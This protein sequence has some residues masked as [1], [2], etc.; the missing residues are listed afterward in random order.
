M[1]CWDGSFQFPNR[2]VPFRTLAARQS[3]VRRAYRG[4]LRKHPWG[5][6]GLRRTF[7][8]WS[9]L[10]S[11]RGSNR[12]GP[13]S[14]SG[15]GSPSLTCY[16][17]RGLSTGPVTFRLGPVVTAQ[18]VVWWVAMLR[19]GRL[20]PLPFRVSRKT[21]VTGDNFRLSPVDLQSSRSTITEGLV[22]YLFCSLQLLSPRGR[23]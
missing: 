5:F 8:V 20:P 11:F 2:T 13:R 16:H 18:A 6:F 1:P 14:G 15:R 19:L 12:A 21:W 10:S 9:I 17:I 7:V 23:F 4:R 22:P 3:S